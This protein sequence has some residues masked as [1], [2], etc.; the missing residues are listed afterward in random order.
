MAF[1]ASY[2]IPRFLEWNLIYNDNDNCIDIKEEKM[3]MEKR[4]FLTVSTTEINFDELS[5]QCIAI[6]DKSILNATDLRRNFTYNLVIKIKIINAKTNLLLP[7]YV[8]R[9]TK[10]FSI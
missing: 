9:C 4:N 5:K 3:E 2:N 8:F 7:N 1:A 10:T 6:N